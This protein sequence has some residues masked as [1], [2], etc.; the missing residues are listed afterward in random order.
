MIERTVFDRI[1]VFERTVDGRGEDTD[2]FSRI[3]R[4]GIAAWYIPTAIVHHLT[5][6]E[7]LKPDYLLSL[8][9][10]MG[11][12]IALRQSA[13]MSRARFAL[14]VAAKAARLA[15]VQMPL[16]LVA[17]VLNDRH[18]WLGRR[19]LAA[20]ETSFLRGAFC[21]LLTPSGATSAPSSA[22]RPLLSSSPPLSLPSLS[23]NSATEVFHS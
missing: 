14:L 7:R 22:A 20:I 18:A 6:A 15:A 2:L 17:A 4:A 19:C 3:E 8:S 23:P 10:R 13:A 11:A 5:P 9:R 12:G 1:G 21:V 16:L